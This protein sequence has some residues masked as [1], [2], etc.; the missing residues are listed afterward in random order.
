MRAIILAGGKGVRLKPYTTLIPKPLVPLGGERSVLE[1]VVM[2][3]AKA[4]FK[5][6]TLAVSHLSDLVMAYFGNGNKWG[7]DIDYSL[8]QKP[9]NTIGPLTI[10]RDLPED[11]LV[12]NS[13]V[14]CN[15]DFKKFF[16]E[17]VR[18]KSQVSVAACQ[19]DSVVDF[20]VLKYD[21]NNCLTEFYEK[22]THRFEVSMGIYCFNRSAIG[23]LPKNQ[24]YG[25][26]QLMTDGIR[27]KSV[28]R[29]FS[30]NGFWLDIGR[31]EDYQYADEHYE[32][33]KKKIGLK[34]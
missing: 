11:F 33:I 1:L 15:L 32:E 28:I 10:I 29:I 12:M 13:D 34:K 20:G 26:D 17:H 2:Q 16:R 14:L 22:P 25:F 24:P 8:E 18:T 27:N 30:F 31:P 6:V 5:R 4:G 7:I 3:L 23:K 21:S 9:L 19:R